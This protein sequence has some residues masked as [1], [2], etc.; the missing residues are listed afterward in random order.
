M[1]SRLSRIRYL[2][3]ASTRFLNADISCPACK[4]MRT[5]FVRR[6]YGVTSLYRC[7]ACELMFRVPKPTPEECHEF[8]QDEYEQG[9]TTDCPSPHEL[10][11]MKDSSFAG[12][13]KDYAGYIDVLRSIPL[14]RGSTILDFGCS[15]GYG[16]WQ[17]ARA[18]YKVYSFEVSR[19]RARYAAEM[20][21]C[22]LC[23][24]ENLP[25]KVDCLFSSHVIEHL[26]NPR[27]VWEVARNVVKPGGIVVHFLPNGDPSRE[28]VDM[29]YH[30]HWGQV[31][32]LLISPR[33]LRLMAETYGFV[34]H[35][36]TAPYDL[37]EI[38]A[39]TAG[40]ETGWELLVVASR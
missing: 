19:P 15:W 21:G 36:Y 6:K 12:T 23:S 20:L 8:Y 33:S 37:Q 13:P 35:C 9:F 16:S 14:P 7:A 25:E 1:A 3:W 18:G 2:L 17:I 40:D 28:R 39:K 32:P 10:K 11:K 22:K 30:K 38:A 27:Q 5:V 4:E 29:N 24:P 34:P 26:T 31:H